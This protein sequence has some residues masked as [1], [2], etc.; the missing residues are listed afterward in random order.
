MEG[1]TAGTRL[2]RWW[3]ELDRGW[4]AVV[5]GYLVVGVVVLTV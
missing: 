5:L 1:D 4:Q 3:T 2:H